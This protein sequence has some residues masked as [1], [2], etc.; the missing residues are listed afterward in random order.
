MMRAGKLFIFAYFL[1]FRATVSNLAGGTSY[2][3]SVK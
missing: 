2:A 1:A 3:S